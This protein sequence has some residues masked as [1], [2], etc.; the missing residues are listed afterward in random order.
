[1]S[2][3]SLLWGLSLGL[4]DGALYSL[5]RESYSIW[6]KQERANGPSN[7]MT[8]LWQTLILCS[9]IGGFI[10]PYFYFWAAYSVGSIVEIHIYRC[11]I[12][13]LISLFIG[14]IVYND[15][16]DGFRALGLLF[17]VVGISLVLFSTAYGSEKGITLNP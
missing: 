15:T 12:S 7:A 8:K 11:M 4:I 1:M 10:F 16:V 14:T 6:Q 9:I 2:A 13:I 5:I 17:T 3:P